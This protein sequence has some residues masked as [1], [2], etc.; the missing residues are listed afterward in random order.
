MKNKVLIPLYLYGKVYIEE[1]DTCIYTLTINNTW[2]NISIKITIRN[3]CKITNSTTEMEILNAGM[4]HFHQNIGLNGYDKALALSQEFIL[5]NNLQ[6]YIKGYGL[7]AFNYKADES[8]S[9]PKNLN[10]A[11]STNNYCYDR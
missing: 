6:V 10:Y 4:V 7:P 2:F 5:M 9:T 8:Q 11:E 1:T 3:Y